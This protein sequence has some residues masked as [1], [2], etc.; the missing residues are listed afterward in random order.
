VRNKLLAILFIFILFAQV[1][2]LNG[3]QQRFPKPEFEQGHEQPPTITPAP[4]SIA[5]E[6]IDIILLTACLSLASWMVIKKRT[7]RGIFWLSLFCLVYFGFI[8]AGCICPVGSVQ[9]ISLALFN[10]NYGIPITVIAIFVLPLFFTLFFGRVFCAGVCPLGAIQDFFI[11]NPVKLHPWVQKAFG[12][13][14]F[15]YL[16]LGILYAATNTDFIICRYDPFVGIFRFNGTFFMYVIGGIL[17]LT[18]VFIARPYCRFFC[19]YGVLLNWVS[20]FSKKHMTITPTTCIQ[21]RLC[22]DSCPMG[23]INLPLEKPKENRNKTVKRLMIFSFIIPLLVLGGGWTGARFHENLASVNPKVRLAQEMLNFN[24]EITDDT[25][26]EIKAFKTSGQPLEEL[27]AEASVI[28]KKF[29]LGGWL[30]GGFIGLVFGFTLAGLS[31]FRYRK[32]YT[33]DK[34]TCLSCLRCTEY[35]PV[36]TEIIISN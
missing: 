22:E 17:L 15:I 36:D 18:G 28:L 34:G 12:I 6:I 2:N 11:I 30:L 1:N 31:V 20:R 26:E 4:R 19:P 24:E 35:C 3:Q 25:S 13:I 7:R 14:P 32:D 5:L 9:N 21:C 27:Y 33:P 16:G 23:A 10:S 8:R 29:H